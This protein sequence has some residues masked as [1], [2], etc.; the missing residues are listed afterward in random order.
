MSCN[1]RTRD[2]SKRRK[3][4]VGELKRDY[5]QAQDAYWKLGGQQTADSRMSTDGRHSKDTQPCSGP[6]AQA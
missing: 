1:S 2:Q 3:E 5:E 6:Q 4:Q